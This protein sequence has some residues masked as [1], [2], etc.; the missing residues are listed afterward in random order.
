MY[1]G[2]TEKRKKKNGI[3]HSNENDAV[4]HSKK[5]FRKFPFHVVVVP[6]TKTKQ[7]RL[8]VYFARCTKQQNRINRDRNCTFVSI[9]QYNSNSERVTELTKFDVNNSSDVSDTPNIERVPMKSLR[10]LIAFT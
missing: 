3:V 1:F 4:A 7:L 10:N 2:F 9:Q 8:L 6:V 5:C